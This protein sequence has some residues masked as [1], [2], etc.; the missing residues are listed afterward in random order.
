[1]LIVI[2]TVGVFQHFGGLDQFDNKISATYYAAAPKK[3]DYNSALVAIDTAS[4]LADPS[5]PWNRDRYAQLIEKLQGSGA[6]AIVFDIDFSATRPG[7]ALFADAIKESQIPVYLVRFQSEYEGLPGV[8]AEIAPSEILSEHAKMITTLFPLENDGGVRLMQPGTMFSD[9]WVPHLSVALSAKDFPESARAI[10]FAFDLSALPTISF[11]EAL[12]AESFGDGL[13]GKVVFIGATANELG[14]E[15]TTPHLGRISGI[16]LNIISYE[17]LRQN[18]DKLPAP[19][20]LYFSILLLSY[21]G[22]TVPAR[23]LGLLTYGLIQA[24]LFIILVMLGYFMQQHLNIILPTA[25]SHLVQLFCSATVI[26]KAADSYAAEV[27]RARMHVAKHARTL[28]ALFSSNHDG[29]VV[30]NHLGRIETANKRAL[31]LLSLEGK[32][33]TGTPTS[34]LLFDLK[35]ITPGEEPKL[36]EL[37]DAHQNDLYI[38]ISCV[39]VV[40]P[41]ENSRYEKRKGLRKLCV[42]TLHDM[43]AQKIV[44]GRE[45]EARIA[46]EKASEAKSTLIGTMSHELRTPLNAVCGF[47]DLIAD[48][49]LGEHASPEY[50]EF[51]D[52]IRKSG[53]HLLNIV[54][55]ML[56]AARFQSGTVETSPKEFLLSDLVEAALDNS[57]KSQ[58]WTDPEVIVNVPAEQVH[59]DYELCKK[60]LEHLIDNASK[61]SGKNGKIIISYQNGGISVRDNG[62]GYKDDDTTTLTELFVQGDG[63]RSRS[64]EGCGLGLFLV[65]NIAALHN[66]SLELFNAAEGGFEAVFALDKANS[67]SDE[68]SATE[69]KNN[70]QEEKWV[71]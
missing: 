59:A 11:T 67:Q 16:E 36:V 3:Q 69:T 18:T 6:S 26:A 70:N 9:G 12:N 2:S 49:A 8:I 58:N 13:N 31:Q 14:D 22:A 61:F 32:N 41:T 37:Q 15:F 21:L 10:D 23:G 35:E 39:E 66:G 56:L 1:M 55:D 60:A 57:K 4:L 29:L 5:W 46:H 51:G 47:A 44:E 40:L 53:K 42:Y 17:N 20:L 48:S 54:N 43:T 63:K 25:G 68:N 19:Y 33:P 7:D 65:Q 30:V 71:A 64:Y 45:R 52:H 38:T 62:P 28:E 50:A 27:F 34:D 24:A